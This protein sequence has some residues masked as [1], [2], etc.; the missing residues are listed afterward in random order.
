MSETGERKADAAEGG[1]L[2]RRA[3]PVPLKTAAKRGLRK[4]GV[5]TASLRALPDFLVIGTKRGGTT[6]FWR[7]L[8]SHPCVLPMMPAAQNLK[9]PHFFYWH[10]QLGESWYRS[11]F[12]LVVH[13][14]ALERRLQARTV[15]GEASPYYFYDPRVPARVAAMLPAVKI[16]VLLRDPVSRAYSH[17][18]ERV[19]QGVEPL[20]F[21]AA[22]QAE[23]VR[24]AGEVEAMAEDPAYYSRAHDWYSYVDRGHYLPQLQ[25]WFAAMPREQVLV[26]SSERFYADPQ[27]SLD[28]T[29]HFLG[30]PVTSLH[31]DRRHNHRPAV[32]MEE[33]LRACLTERYREPNARLYE[34][35]GEDLGWP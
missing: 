20:S 15:T 13:R 5:A 27:A 12:P 34:L 22:L 11:H 30:I 33:A 10:Y 28:R 4:A 23:P 18:W 19:D 32:P 7:Y 21:A 16:I 26:L 6:S 3:A 17:Y 24:L 9:S 1:G 29:A 14:R 25:R 31:T 35:L 8:L 2:L